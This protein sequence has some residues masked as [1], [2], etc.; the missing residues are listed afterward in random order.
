MFRQRIWVWYIT[1]TSCSTTIFP[2]SYVYLRTNYGK[3]KIRKKKKQE[4]EGS[5][6]A[7]LQAIFTYLFPFILKMYL[8]Q[9]YPSSLR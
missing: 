6:I 9:E 1:A 4:Q 7:E 3:Q 2:I 5:E 8:T